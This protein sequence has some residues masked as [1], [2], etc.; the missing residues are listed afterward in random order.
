MNGTLLPLRW[1]FFSMKINLIFKSPM[2][3]INVLNSIPQV[4]ID[5]KMLLTADFIGLNFKMSIQRT[6]WFD[7]VCSKLLD[8]RKQAKLQWLQYPSK[9]N[10][11]DLNNA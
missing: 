1:Q 8:Q 10:W 7:K 4:S 11:V 3:M 6:P 9:L 5:A 2:I